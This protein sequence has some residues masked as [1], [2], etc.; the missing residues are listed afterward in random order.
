MKVSVEQ[1]PLFIPPPKVARSV[2]VHVSGIIRCIAT[3]TGIL[4]PEW[5]EEL[6][7]IEVKQSMRFSDPIVAIRVSMGLAWEDYYIRE[8]L[9]PEGVID[10]PGEYE[11]DGI[12]MS[13]DG[14][15]LSSILIDRRQVRMIKVHE[16]KCTYKST[17]TVGETEGE[18]LSQFMWLAQIK[19]YCHA[20]KSVMAD[21]HVLF[22]CGDYSYPISPIKKRFRIVFE[23]DEILDNWQMLR[24]YKEQRMIIEAERN[25][26]VITPF[27]RNVRGS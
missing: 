7:L 24:E 18:L 21:L 19:A 1:V 9:A 25:K 2:G 13:P 22:V 10:H 15:E 16:V 12:Y 3:E 20:V 23:P 14:E 6:S 5:A 26:N 27:R 17:N 8:I 4:K 11:C